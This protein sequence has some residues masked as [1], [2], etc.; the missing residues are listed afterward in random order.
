MGISS[1]IVEKEM[2]RLKGGRG[3]RDEEERRRR[4]RWRGE[5]GRFREEKVWG[6]KRKSF[7]WLPL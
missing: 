4:R 1:V 3:E 5:E 7:L 2:S 6:K